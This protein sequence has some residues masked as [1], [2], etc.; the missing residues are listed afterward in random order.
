M[1]L[2]C[3][4]SRTYAEDTTTIYKLLVFEGLSGKAASERKYKCPYS[5]CYC[6]DASWLCQEM[7][8]R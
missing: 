8:E 1:Q 3:E 5:L 4:D 7:K 2:N 6:R